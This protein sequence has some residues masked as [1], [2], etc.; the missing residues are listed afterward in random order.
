[1]RTSDER[2]RLTFPQRN[3]LL[4]CLLT[5]FI[6]AIAYYLIESNLTMNKTAPSNQVQTTG[7]RSS[8]IGDTQNAKGVPPDSL[9]H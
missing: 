8:V 2:R 7:S 1:M 6:T 9:G 5:A 4:L 3:W